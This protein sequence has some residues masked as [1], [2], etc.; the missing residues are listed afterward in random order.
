MDIKQNLSSGQTVSDIIIEQ[1]R[2]DEKAS[3]S[4]IISQ[5][6]IRTMAKDIAALSKEAQSSASLYAKPT[7]K[8]G[9]APT[10]SAASPLRPV[11]I[12]PF[13]KK[14]TPPSDLPMF[15]EE[16]KPMTPPAP[17][18]SPPKPTP[19]PPLPK[20]VSPPPPPVLPKLKPEPFSSS[21]AATLKQPFHI[22]PAPAAAPKIAKPQL[23][24]ISLA[25]LGIIVGVLIVVF[26][27][28][29]G[30]FYF[31]N[32]KPTSSPTPSATP[33]PSSTPTPSATPLILP[34]A[35]FNMEEQ[36]VINLAADQKL[37]LYELLGALSQ[38]PASSTFTQV[39]FETNQAAGQAKIAGFDELVSAVN[40]DFFGPLGTNNSELGNSDSSQQPTPS[41]T[42]QPTLSQS[43]LPSQSY[44]KDYFQNDQYS[45]FVYYQTQDGSS[46]FTGGENPGRIGLIIALKNGT[47]ENEL[48]NLLKSSESAIPSALKSLWFSQGV[49]I[50]ATPQ[51]LD[52]TY[53]NIP[54]RYVNFP[55]STLTIDYAI[56]KGYLLI[57]TSKEAMYAA[58][59][60]LLAIPAAASSTTPVAD[61]SNWQTYLNEKYGFEI[62]YPKDWFFKEC[63]SSYVGFSYNQSK[64]P[65]CGT[66]APQPH[67]NIAIS[68]D[69]PIGI[70]KFIE[71][72]QN[73]INN[74]S[75]EQI[76]LN[77]NITATK[78][79][80]TL[81]EI[82]GPGAPAG[83]QFIDVLFLFNNNIYS[84]YYYGL[85]DKDYSSLFNQILSTFSFTK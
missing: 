40:I 80:G 14:A 10:P 34:S 39:V 26:L 9:L 29:G 12:S 25:K 82:E 44:L 59:D 56:V 75:N 73:S 32:V 22:A 33:S 45:V 27:G 76:T 52:N 71:S 69:S 50:P 66:D 17:P 28:I 64:L 8:P 83:T 31:G 85:D 41:S 15:K 57:T 2:E 79:S 11:V 3:V 74:Y 19:P 36:K 61:T 46:P 48:R 58:I 5:L 54:M 37:P 13:P 60:R 42:Q 35:L 4:S 65:P 30:W 6:V 78:L 38:S 7:L 67:I 55:Y 1:E 72:V 81:K 84:I 51:L 68:P 53:K 18:P 63:D 47:N 24:K 70:N 20:P 23:Q 21:G 62:K 16:I 43:P 77:V 49:E